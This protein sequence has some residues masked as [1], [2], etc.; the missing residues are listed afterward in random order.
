MHSFVLSMWT[1]KTVHF[2]SACAVE[3]V[4]RDQKKS[5]GFLLAFA[6]P[7]LVVFMLKFCIGLSL[8]VGTHRPLPPLKPLH[9]WGFDKSCRPLMFLR[10]FLAVLPRKE[11]NNTCLPPARYLVKRWALLFVY[12]IT[13]VSHA[14][15]ILCV[16]Q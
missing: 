1:L 13:S 7:L 12:P 10:D 3:L 8:M 16:H 2:L 15:P 6:T 11:S 4:L 14:R 5:N 9:F